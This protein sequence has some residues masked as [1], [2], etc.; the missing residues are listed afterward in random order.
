MN[1]VEPIRSLNDLEKIKNLLKFKE[2]DYLLF[3]IGIN[4][5]LRISDILNLDVIDVQ[6]KDYI[7]IVEKKT[8][9]HKK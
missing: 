4:T 8:K 9:K 2:R 5:G 7:T 6:N 3:C 1:F